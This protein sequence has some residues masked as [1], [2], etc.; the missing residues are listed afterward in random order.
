MI[1][2]EFDE[3]HFPFRTVD[4]R[5]RGYLDDDAQL[6]TLSLYHDMPNATIEGITQRIKSCKSLVTQNGTWQT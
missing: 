6:E 3:T 2:A 5:V 4:Q 1:H